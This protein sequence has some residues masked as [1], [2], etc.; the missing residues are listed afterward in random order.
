VWAAAAPILSAPLLTSANE[1]TYLSAK[2]AIGGGQIGYNWQVPSFYNMV[3][4][5]EADL[6]ASGQREN[7]CIATCFL[8]S[9]ISI[10][11]QQKIDWF[12][13]VRGRVGLATG[14][15]LSY[16]T[17]GYAY[18]NVSTSGAVTTVAPGVPFSLSETRGGFVL[19][20]GVEASLGGAWTGK[21]EYLYLDLGTQSQQL[22]AAGVFGTPFTVSSHVRDNIFRGGI[23]YRFGGNSTYTAPVGNWSGLYIGGNVGSLTASN[24]SSYVVSPPGNGPNQQSFSLVPDGYE[25]GLQIGYNWQSSAWVFGLEA[26]FQGATSR[27]N[28]TCGG[29]CALSV[30]AGFNLVYDQKVPYFGTV[31]GRLG[32]SIGSTLFYATAG[33]AYGQTNTTL[34]IPGMLVNSFKTGK[35]GYA[36]GAG[37]ESPLRFLGSM[38]GPNWTVKTEYLFVDLG[39]TSFSF[40]ETFV[41]PGTD[42][43]TTRTQEHI[44]RTGLNYYF[45]SPVVAKY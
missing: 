7:D 23:N 8:P 24:P 21:I 29:F 15:V 32:Y 19:G 20:T 13:T 4:G 44:F 33:F 9:G 38:F 35:G 5:I 3:F 27:D 30:P 22:A 36:V 40:A 18:A 39:R 10:N 25:G 14:P 12:G 34:T 45:N 37:I 41:P 16:V 17:G 43:F 1:T 6:Q 42:T 31:R 26:D 2:G 28:R 11:I